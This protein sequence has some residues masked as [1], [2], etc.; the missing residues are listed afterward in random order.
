M[1]VEIGPIE[2]AKVIACGVNLL[3]SVSK[4]VYA[5]EDG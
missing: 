5:P 4:K 1:L 2:A 3:D